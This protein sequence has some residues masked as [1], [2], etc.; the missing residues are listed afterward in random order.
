MERVTKVKARKGKK[1][2]GWLEP[3]MPYKKAKTKLYDLMLLCWNSY[4]LTC[5]K[6]A[7]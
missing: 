5:N 1:C 6:T 7:F 4:T 3:L 2:E